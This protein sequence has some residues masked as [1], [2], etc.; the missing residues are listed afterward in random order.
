MSSPKL[1][2]ILLY[3]RKL[4]SSKCWEDTSVES[5]NINGKCV[6]KKKKREYTLSKYKSRKVLQPVTR[7]WPKV[8]KKLCIRSNN[9]KCRPPNCS[10]TQVIVSHTDQQDCITV[11]FPNQEAVKRLFSAPYNILYSV[12][13]R[14]IHFCNYICTMS[15]H[16]KSSREN[17]KMFFLKVFKNKN[18]FVIYI[19]ILT[20]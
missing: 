20:Y 16:F 4:Y 19:E 2:R 13:E 10:G 15:S 9:L 1:S 5:G 3:N 14:V 12:N 17:I 6:C 18:N 11:F 8:D 7:N